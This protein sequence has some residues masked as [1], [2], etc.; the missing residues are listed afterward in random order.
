MDRLRI[1]LL[2]I[3]ACGNDQAANLEKGV[4][5]CK[6]AAR[7]G[8]EIIVFPEMWNIGYQGYLRTQPE[9]H[10][11]WM[12]QAIGPGSSFVQAFCALARQLKVNVALTYL[13]KW[14]DMPR[15][16]VS[17]ITKEGKIALTY[18]KV[19]TCD[20]NVHMG[21]YMVPEASCAPGDDFF[22][23]EL[24]TQVGAVQIGLMICYD[25]EF[26]E[27]SRILMLKGAEIVL[28]PNACWLD[29]LRLHQFQARAFE[30]MT[31]MA[32]ANYP[33]P[34]HYNG[35]SVAFDV[36]GSCLVEAGENEGIVIAEFDLGRLRS[37]RAEH[38][39]GN[40]FRRP[41]RYQEL[42]S[43]EVRQPFSRLNG[44]GQLFERQNR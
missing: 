40:A 25:R 7:L 15:N 19:H 6:E 33:A 31:G 37:W 20:F 26:P 32:M 22:V 24:D 13:E 29:D 5:F 42:L 28:T 16:S 43:P 11:L 39:W 34:G 44:L 12:Q 35:R 9:A 14:Q 2:Q 10:E 8:A 1:A 36:D 30:N 4:Y 27:S 3:A 41:H 21:Q 38:I 23:C 17:L 18:A